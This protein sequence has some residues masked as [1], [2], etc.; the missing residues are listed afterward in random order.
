M[1]SWALAV[2]FVFTRVR[3]EFRRRLYR[4]ISSTRDRGLFYAIVSAPSIFEGCLCWD[5]RIFPHRILLL[6]FRAK[7]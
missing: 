1:K 5:G 7:R 3:Y 2:V 4:T 6:M